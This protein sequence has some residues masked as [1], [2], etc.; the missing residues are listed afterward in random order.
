[1]ENYKYIAKKLEEVCIRR[2]AYDFY[3]N[4]HTNFPQLLPVLDE[5]IKGFRTE[6]LDFAKIDWDL[7]RMQTFILEFYQNFDEELAEKVWSVLEDETTVLRVGKPSEKGGVN[8]VGVV[9]EEGEIRNTHG[10]ISTKPDRLKKKEPHI[11]VE[12]HPTNDVL[13]FVAV[14]HEF[15][16]IMEERVQKKLPQKTDCLGEISSMFMERVFIQF[17]LNSGKIDKKQYENFLKKREENFV[18]NVR[19]LLEEDEI[20]RQLHTPFSADEIEN[21]YKKYDGTQHGEILRKRVDTM[22]D[23]NQHVYGEHCYRY[24]VGEVVS[25]IMFDDYQKNPVATLDRFKNF[26][27]TNAEIDEK[28]AFSLLLGENYAQRMQN[29]LQDGKKKE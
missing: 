12:L 23:D 7:G 21:L 11:R 16:H 15:A 9:V 27:E 14:A 25:N 8:A 19:T 28:Q 10:K 20:L 5:A 24:I 18:S 6:R 4:L 29:A 17:L 3:N 26:L 13:G 1:M 22:I 2:N